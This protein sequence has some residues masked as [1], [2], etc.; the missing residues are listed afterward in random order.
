MLFDKH[1]SWM[2][3]GHHLNRICH[4]TTH[5][6]TVMQMYKVWSACSKIDK[7]YQ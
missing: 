4:R 5:Y 3:P 2:L 7:V 6:E 1:M